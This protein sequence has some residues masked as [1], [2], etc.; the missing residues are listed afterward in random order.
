[1]T[2]RSSQPDLRFVVAGMGVQGVKRRAIV[3]ESP[4]VT[5]DPFAEGVDF[6]RL[7]EV[8]VDEFDA[9]YLCTPDSAKQELVE[10]A[11]GHGKHVLIEKPFNLTPGHYSSLSTLAQSTGATIYVA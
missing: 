5:V 9:V 2:P 6:T 8:P 4:C 1:M 11:V 10:Y 7:D 3:G